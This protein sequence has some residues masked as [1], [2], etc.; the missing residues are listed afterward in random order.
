MKL[1]KLLSII[2]A[3]IMVFSTE[4]VA[5]ATDETKG[6][7]SEMYLCVS[8]ETSIGRGESTE[9][10]VKYNSEKLD[11]IKF[12]WST[13][14]DACNIEYFADEESG[15]ITRAK[16][17]AV[18][19]GYYYIKVDMFSED[20]KIIESDKQTIFS[21]VPEDM[22]LQEKIEY[23]I[24]KFGA[25]LMFVVFLILNVILEPIGQILNLFK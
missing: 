7:T 2:L 25:N 17:T 22:S 13:D 23:K 11:N 5:F 12:V 6:V 10:T 14:G 1:K 3:V 19:Y 16:I 24:S 4:V 18:T 20:G 21:N 8:G 15:L 9:V